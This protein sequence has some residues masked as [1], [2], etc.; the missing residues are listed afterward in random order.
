MHHFNIL[1]GMKII[2]CSQVNIICGSSSLFFQTSFWQTLRSRLLRLR[3]G[4]LR[5]SSRPPPHW[6]ISLQALSSHGEALP[7][8]WSRSRPIVEDAK[9]LAQLHL[10]VHAVHLSRHHGQKFLE[11]DCAAAVCV[12]LTD[13]VAHLWLGGTQTQWACHGTELVRRNVP[14]AIFVEQRKGL[15]ILGDLLLGQ[16]LSHFETWKKSWRV[17]GNESQLFAS[18]KVFKGKLEYLGTVLMKKL[19][20]DGV[21][22]AWGRQRRI[23]QSEAL[24]L[25]QELVRASKWYPIVCTLCRMQQAEKVTVKMCPDVHGIG[26]CAQWHNHCSHMR[27]CTLCASWHVTRAQASAAPVNRLAL[28]ARSRPP[29]DFGAV[30]SHRAAAAGCGTRRSRWGGVWWGSSVWHSPSQRSNQMTVT[31]LVENDSDQTMRYSTTLALLFS[32]SNPAKCD[33]HSVHVRRKQNFFK[34]CSYVD[35]NTILVKRKELSS[36]HTS[37]CSRLVRLTFGGGSERSLWKTKR[38]RSA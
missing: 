2:L 6:S 31:A 9:R 30:A 10:S 17:K 19:H 4:Q 18:L 7:S 3:S 38:C 15:L 36:L 29:T 25:H 33:T 34:R 37:L 12:Y 20:L 32:R 8:W 27:V 24:W 35:S 21:F 26:Y 13:H 1:L 28:T 22:Y 11:V 5:E 16:K 23:A 14:V